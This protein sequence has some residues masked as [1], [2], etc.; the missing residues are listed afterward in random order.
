MRV[1]KFGMWDG[2]LP[3]LPLVRRLGPAY[4]CNDI[5]PPHTP[6]YPQHPP[7]NN[8]IWQNE[9][10]DP[11]GKMIVLGWESRRRKPWHYLHWEL[12]SRKLFSLRLFFCFVLINDDFF[13]KRSVIDGEAIRRGSIPI[14]RSVRTPFSYGQKSPKILGFMD[15]R[16]PKS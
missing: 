2:G 12:L 11:C 5:C 10:E 4:L 3:W 7:N 8:R 9:T 6:S 1:G 16:G 14:F 13:N 15:K